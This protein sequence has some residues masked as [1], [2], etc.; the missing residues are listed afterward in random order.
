[1]DGQ[2]LVELRPQVRLTVIAIGFMLIEE[3][4]VSTM[5]A[6][7]SHTNLHCPRLRDFR[8]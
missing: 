4:L 8:P 6:F 5:H 3:T 1:M 2:K 7:R